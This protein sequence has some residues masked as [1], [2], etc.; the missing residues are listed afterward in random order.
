[1]KYEYAVRTLANNVTERIYPEQ[2]HDKLLR[3]TLRREDLKDESG[4][5]RLYV[6]YRSDAPH[7]YA[8]SKIRRN[9]GGTGHDSEN[10]DRK[11]KGLVT[12]GNTT[13]P[14]TIGHY[15]FAGP[16]DI[17]FVPLCRLQNYEWQSERKFVLSDD[18]YVRFDVL[19]RSGTMNLTEKEPFVAI[20]VVD[21]HF[22]EQEA[23]TALREFSAKLPL[24][25]LY[26]YVQSD[27]KLNHMENTRGEA[28]RL[29]ITHYIADGSFW[30]NDER[31]EEKYQRLQSRIG[32]DPALYYN[33][34]MAE[35]VN[36]LIGKR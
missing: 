34:V 8:R 10:H 12:Y 1:M 6:R 31:F 14:L 5:Y 16:K 29:R 3:E 19:G 32:N 26:Y 35:V 27:G 21:T 15:E 25:V 23:F 33:A 36:K 28:G 4:V 20:E 22:S 13:N 17:E 30:I 9:I 7:F 2:L 24:I 11:V 18:T